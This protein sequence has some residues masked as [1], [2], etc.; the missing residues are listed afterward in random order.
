MA[1]TAFGPHGPRIALAI[2][3]DAYAWTRLGLVQFADEALNHVPNKDAAF[4]PE[5]VLSPRGVLSFAF[6]HRPML[7]ESVNGQ[8]PIAADLVA[9]AGAAR[10]DVHRVRSRRGRAARRP[11]SCPPVRESVRVLPVGETWGVLKNGA[12]TPPVR[13]SA[14][15]LSFFH[16]VDVLQHAAGS[17][18][19]YRAGIVDARSR[20]PGP[21]DLPLAGAVARSADARRTRRHRQRRRVP[22]RAST[23]LSEGRYDVYYGAADARIARARVDVSFGDTAGALRSPQR[24]EKRAGA[25]RSDAACTNVVELPGSRPP[26]PKSRT[27]VFSRLSTD[28]VLSASASRYRNQTRRSSG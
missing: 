17:S 26:G 11:A 16:G 21:G 14:G 24:N 27:A 10:S 7:R 25:R 28:F 19:Y 20:A 22:D 23:C 3:D 1:Y 15:W 2:S 8:A 6:Y 18:L 4:F 13:T 12:G 9:A 5:P